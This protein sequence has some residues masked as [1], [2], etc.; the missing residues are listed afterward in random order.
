MSA[1]TP[2]G[3]Y[4]PGSSVV[5]RLTPGPKLVGLFVLGIAVLMVRGPWTGIAWLA[6]VLCVAL[7]ARLSLVS[8]GRALRGF[9]VV[10]VLLLVFNAWQ[11]GWAQAIEVVADL[12]A[13]ILG[14]TVLTATTR[15]D[16]LL[17]TI[18][19]GLG[20]FRRIGVDPERVGLTF[21]LMLRAVPGT[22]ELA[23]ETRDAARARGLERSIR[24]R[25]TPLVLRVVARARDTG[26]ALHARGIVD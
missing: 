23:A 22:L 14:A 13:L 9:A 3:L 7:V 11:N 19:R 16:D 6:L 26:D 2:L 21:S 1:G 15:V 10:A 24:A 12:F 18:V 17:D 25:T 5:H 20:P 4:Q 8:M